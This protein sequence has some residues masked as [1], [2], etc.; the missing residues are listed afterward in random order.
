M[1]KCS[2]RWLIITFTPRWLVPQWAITISLIKSTSA[3]SGIHHRFCSSLHNPLGCSSRCSGRVHVVASC[4]H[5]MSSSVGHSESGRNGRSSTCTCVSCVCQRLTV[6]VSLGNSMQA[7]REAI[8]A[9]TLSSPLICSM[10]YRSSFSF[11]L[12]RCNF[13]RTCFLISSPGA[14]MKIKLR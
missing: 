5:L 12:Q 9:H 8:S 11:K 1:W 4:A 3:S 13:P 2:W 6:V 14:N 10:V 7:Q